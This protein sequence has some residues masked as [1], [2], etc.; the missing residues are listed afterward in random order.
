MAS[1]APDALL[2]ID[3]ETELLPAAPSDNQTSP[4][5]RDAPEITLIKGNAPP[6]P[7]MLRCEMKTPA[8]TTAIK[9][10]HTTQAE[11]TAPETSPTRAP[12]TLLDDVGEVMR[13]S[14]S[15]LEHMSTTDISSAMTVAML[16]ADDDSDAD[17]LPLLESE[18]DETV[19]LLD[20]EP[21]GLPAAEWVVCEAESGHKYYYNTRT[22]VSQWEA[23]TLP[24]VDPNRDAFFL[25]V[26]SGDAPGATSLLQS[27]GRGLLD[28]L[29]DDGRSAVWYALG[30][31][32]MAQVLF[33]F[34]AN[35][36]AVDAD[37]NG[38]IH[39]V[40]RQRNVAML[41]LLLAFGADVNLRDGG[42]QT[43]LHI[44][45]ACGYRR[46]VQVLLR[47]G[48][49]VHVLDAA[50]RTPLQLSTL[51]NHVACV[52]LLQAPMSPANAH[53]QRDGGPGDSVL[54][55]HLH[56]TT[57][58]LEECKR[59][60]DELHDELEHLHERFVALETAHRI[61]NARIIML[62]AVVDR[63]EKEL[64]HER[65]LLVEKEQIYHEERQAH[66]ETLQELQRQVDAV[67]QSTW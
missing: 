41:A 39:V 12:A 29:D 42:R 27:F 18:S 43:A 64:E 21:P 31:A 59:E 67:V 28:L 58:R 32:S 8:S 34:G 3:A 47:H 49:T 2:L 6:P 26:A 38:P 5:P 40:T 55:A 50:A 52:Q 10:D 33:E 7:L 51:G 65:T 16:A 14:W 1:E 66:Y 11:P 20:T 54:A 45:A 56:D 22:H 36:D 46:C 63:T 61:A 30:N 37:A 13:G 4:L 25:A 60:R 24:S 35:L 19:S 15:S 53:R 23:P 62:E 9:V 17:D 48:A 44:A 57:S